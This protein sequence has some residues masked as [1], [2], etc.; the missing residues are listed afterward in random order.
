[1][2]LIV[3]LLDPQQFYSVT[4]LAKSGSC[5]E[6]AAIK[7]Q[8]GTCPTRHTLVKAAKQLAAE[9]ADISLKTWWR[10]KELKSVTIG[11]TS[12]RWPVIFFLPTVRD[13]CVKKTVCAG[14]MA[15]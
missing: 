3:V 1:M 14:N 12:S 4:S 13:E 5:K 9:E 8:C 10:L 15:A 2:F 7:L 6:R 11:F